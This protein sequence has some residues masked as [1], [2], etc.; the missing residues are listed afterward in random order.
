VVS[1]D[2]RF[3]H[4]AAFALLGLASASPYPNRVLLMMSSL[5]EAR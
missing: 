5:P 3:E 4:F 2:I 1:A